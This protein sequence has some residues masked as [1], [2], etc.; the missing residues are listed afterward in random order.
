V[1]RCRT[2]CSALSSRRFL[3]LLQSL[4][5]EI[6]VDPAG[7]EVL[8]VPDALAVAQEQK[9]AVLMGNRSVV[10]THMRLQRL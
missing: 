7:E 8:E 2:L 9:L 6:D 3:R 5:G 10:K 1:K 4:G